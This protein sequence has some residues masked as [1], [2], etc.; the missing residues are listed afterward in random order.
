MQTRL[1]AYEFPPKSEGG[2]YF[3]SDISRGDKK[4]ENRG[5][6]RRNGVGIMTGITP[7]TSF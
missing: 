4:D 1:I 6:M 7:G 3:L 2:G 5:I